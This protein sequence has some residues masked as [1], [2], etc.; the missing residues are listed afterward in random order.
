LTIGFQKLSVTPSRATRGVEMAV[1]RP[2]CCP[3]DNVTVY[4][5]ALLV[6]GPL[7]VTSSTLKAS[8][9]EFGRL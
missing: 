5:G 9:P 7:L 2:Y 4:G 1:M 6:A 3:D 8:A